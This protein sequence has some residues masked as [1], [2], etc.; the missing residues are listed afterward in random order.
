MGLAQFIYFKSSQEDLIKLLKELGYEMLEDGSFNKQKSEMSIE[1]R[2]IERGIYIHRSGDYFE[3][4]GIL[5]EN[6]GSIASS[7]AIED[8]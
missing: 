7:I 3:E 6:L 5:I 1:I 8:Q 2:I 4:L